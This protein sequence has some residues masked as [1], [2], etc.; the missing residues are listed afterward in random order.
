MIDDAN[1]SD[2][3]EEGKGEKHEVLVNMLSGTSSLSRNQEWIEET[4]P[5]I[6]IFR[7]KTAE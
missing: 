7:S 5:R 3:E 4:S 1:F 6:A 2:S